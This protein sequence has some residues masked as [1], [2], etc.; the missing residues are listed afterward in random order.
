MG[1][2]IFYMELC[3]GQYTG[4][5]PVQAYRRM[6]PAFGGLGVCTLVVIGLITIYYMVI[7]SWTL[8]YILVS[9]NPNPGWAYCNNDFNTARKFGIFV[10]NFGLLTKCCI[11]LGVQP[12]QFT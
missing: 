3:I 5:G 6:A 12:L 4:L 11:V 7:V 8:F 10:D 2:P 1:L 9:F